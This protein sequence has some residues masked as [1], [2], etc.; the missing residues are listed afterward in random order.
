MIVGTRPDSRACVERGDDRLDPQAVRV[1]A[2]LDRLVLV[3][4]A[5][6]AV[7]A[8][9]GQHVLRDGQV[10]DEL[11]DVGV[12][13]DLELGGMKRELTFVGG[14]AEGRRRLL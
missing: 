11:A 10:G 7:Q 13:G 12:G 8:E 6:G 14:T 1:R 3:D 9:L 4:A 2:L 5:A